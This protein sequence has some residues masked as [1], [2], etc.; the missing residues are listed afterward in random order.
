MK[1]PLNCPHAYHGP[2]MRVLCRRNEKLC[3]HQQFKSC[4][5]WWVLSP[6]AERC[7]LRKEDKT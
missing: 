3:G 6:Q 1:I 5:G 7:P 4:K 2:G